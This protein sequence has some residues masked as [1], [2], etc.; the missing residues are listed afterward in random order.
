MTNP[1]TSQLLLLNQLLFL[2]MRNFIAG[3]LLW[4]SSLC[5]RL[6]RVCIKLAEA[7]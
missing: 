3:Q 6:A 5:I 7:L 1:T 2:K 4:L